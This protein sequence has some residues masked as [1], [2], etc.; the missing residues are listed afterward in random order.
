MTLNILAGVMAVGSVSA[1]VFLLVLFEVVLTTINYSLM[2]ARAL[3]TEDEVDWERAFVN[4]VDSAPA[5]HFP[6]TSKRVLGQE[7]A[8]GSRGEMLC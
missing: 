8:F 6:T 1:F 4:E 2:K 3:V 5:Q 7:D